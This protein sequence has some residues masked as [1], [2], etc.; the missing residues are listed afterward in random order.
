MTTRNFS[1]TAPPVALTGA[2]VPTD[3]SLVVA[4]T[5]G[6]PAAPFLLGL[7]RGTANEEV[8]LCTASTGTAFTVT[9]GFDGTTAKSHAVGTSIEHTVAAIDYREP[10]AH[11]NLVN[12]VN[13]LA[14]G[15]G[16]TISGTTGD[17]TLVALPKTT[18]HPHTFN[19]AGQI[20]TTTP[21]PGMVFDIPAGQTV[22]LVRAR[23]M[24]LS[25][26]S[27]TVTLQKNGVDITGWT[28][29]SVSTTKTLLDGPD[30]AFADGDRFSL[31]VTAISG[32]PNNLLFSAAFDYT[33]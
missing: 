9:R 21:I 18:R 17:I 25:G 22:T 15:L 13:S 5:T 33:A 30:V 3:T 27:A 7:E 23:H 8:V 16:M 28:G 1:N 20:D 19:I 26:T 12:H 32:V 4:T 2:V 6:Y 24:I 31:V 11:I 29:I 10:N 14:A